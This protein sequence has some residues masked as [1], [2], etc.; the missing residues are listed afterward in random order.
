[1]TQHASKAAERL[2]N[3]RSA[4]AAC[5]FNVCQVVMHLLHQIQCLHATHVGQISYCTPTNVTIIISSILKCKHNIIY[6]TCCRHAHT[7]RQ[8]TWT[9]E[10]WSTSHLSVQ[11]YLASSTTATVSMYGL[12]RLAEPETGQQC[13][14]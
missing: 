3:Y 14:L 9:K 11:T 2:P 1:M 13:S 7:C 4:A 6:C 12:Q 5:G 10:H 8:S